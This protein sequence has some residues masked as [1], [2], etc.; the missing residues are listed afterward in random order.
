MKEEGLEGNVIVQE[1]GL[2]LSNGT[3]AARKF[4]EKVG[5]G[6]AIFGKLRVLCLVCGFQVLNGGQVVSKVGRSGAFQVLEDSTTC[7]L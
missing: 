4:E 5:W 2:N 1:Q 7:I 3:G 6:W